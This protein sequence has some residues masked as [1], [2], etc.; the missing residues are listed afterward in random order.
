MKK[1]L[2][3]S[4]AIKSEPRLNEIGLIP[5]W[6]LVYFDVDSREVKT[7]FLRRH[8]VPCRLPKIKMCLTLRSQGGLVLPGAR[9]FLDPP[10]LEKTT[11]KLGMV[12]LTFNPRRK[13]QQIYDFEVTSTEWQVSGQSWYRKSPVSSPHKKSNNYESRGGRWIKPRL[14][15]QTGRH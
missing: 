11:M 9:K 1:R 3:P 6:V 12:M 7:L 5:S 10:L 13:K 15:L 4:Y 2:Y 8:H 14:P